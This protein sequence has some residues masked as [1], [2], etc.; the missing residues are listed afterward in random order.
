MRV[1]VAGGTGVV[2]AKVVDRLSELGHDPVVLA[3]SRGTDLTSGD[4]VEE[5]LAGVHAVV[6]ATSIATTS[7]AAS[8]EFFT[9]VTRNLTRAGE[10]AG[11]AHHVALSIVGIDDIPFGYYQGKV[12]H[13]QAVAA[14]SV[15]WSILRATQ[16]LEFPGQLVERA[17]VGPVSFVPQMLSQPVAAVEVASA[18]VDLALGEPTGRVPDLAGPREE[19]MVDL[20]RRLVR[21]RGE[22]RRVVGIPVPGAAGRAM[23]DGGLLPTGPGPRGTLTFDAWLASAR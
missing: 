9:T 22:R 2:G 12:A 10:A 13:E 21:H 18:L 17:K 6:D 7:R 3:R 1:A 5:A 8:V 4:G 20:A 19:Q 11:V 14:A 15:P 16:F 23:R